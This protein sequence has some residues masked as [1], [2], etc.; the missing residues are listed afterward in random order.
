MSQGHS[1]VQGFNFNS[2]A[3]LGLETGSWFGDSGPVTEEAASWD[4]E[5]TSHWPS[6]NDFILPEIKPDFWAKRPH[7]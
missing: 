5:L 6:P 2:L 4:V 7:A 3:T 1:A